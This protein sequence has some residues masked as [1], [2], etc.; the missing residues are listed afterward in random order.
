MLLTCDNLI[1]ICNAQISYIVEKED[2]SSESSCLS[3]RAYEECIKFI[4]QATSTYDDQ[5]SCNDAIADKCINSLGNAPNG[6]DNFIDAW[7][8]AMLNIWF[9]STTDISNMTP[10]Q[11]EY[12]NSI[13]S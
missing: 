2:S 8:N 13:I 10:K 11:R 5:K 12:I 6:T 4:E 9:L 3:K 1:D 7:N